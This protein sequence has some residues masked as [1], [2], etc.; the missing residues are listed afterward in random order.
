MP[1]DFDPAAA[2][3]LAREAL[4][5]SEKATPGPWIAEQPYEVQ[6]P[7]PNWITQDVRGGDCQLAVAFEPREHFVVPRNAR[8]KHTAGWIA[9]ARTREPALARAVLAAAERVRELERE[10]ERL[11]GW[12]KF[13]SE[14][15]ADP[16]DMTWGFCE[17]IEC[18]D[19]ALRGVASPPAPEPR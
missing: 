19:A 6:I 15:G 8:M 2:E 3:K 10:S 17:A 12:L 14:R 11:R 5:D 9:A 16:E 1:A 13:V 7:D 4:A 18:V